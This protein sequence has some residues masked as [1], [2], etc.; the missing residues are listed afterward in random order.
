M[1][2]HQSNVNGHGAGWTGDATGKEGYEKMI[3]QIVAVLAV[4]AVII[5][6]FVAVAYLAY[7]FGAD[8]RPGI[9]DTD[10]RPWLVPGA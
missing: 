3:E 2:P 10:R 1:R 8:S 7:R 6:P 4:A 9:D 5:G